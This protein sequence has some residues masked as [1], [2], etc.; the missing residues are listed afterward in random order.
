MCIKTI[1]L[2]E[3][4]RNPRAESR[5]AR[6]RKEF[7]SNAIATAAMEYLSAEEATDL[8]F[9]SLPEA[10]RALRRARRRQIAA[11][12]EEE[13]SFLFPT[14][15]GQDE[16]PR[17][18]RPNRRL[19]RLNRSSI[20]PPL[21][22]D[23]LPIKSVSLIE[24]LITLQEEYQGAPA[25][26]LLDMLARASGFS[27]EFCNHTLFKCQLIRTPIDS[28]DMEAIR[29]ARGFRAHYSEGRRR[30]ATLVATARVPQCEGD[31]AYFE[32]R[33]LEALLPGV[34]VPTRLK[35]DHYFTNLTSDRKELTVDVHTVRVLGALFRH[36]FVEDF[37][38][39]IFGKPPSERRLC[40]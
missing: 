13:G 8:A 17:V 14:V 40:C 11:A 27:L 39:L 29:S 30:Y 21:V 2:A 35:R 33:D 36:P 26:H 28:A 20:F 34:A 23:E 24:I 31:W 3:F 1:R 7:F 10:K 37:N 9:G 22:A 19:S 15:A 25:H 18:P 5:R 38:P 32:D 6:R 16:L 12:E 4:S